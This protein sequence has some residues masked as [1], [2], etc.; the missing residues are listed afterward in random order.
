MC[1]P[2]DSQVRTLIRRLL[3]DPRTDSGSFAREKLLMWTDAGRQR[4]RQ[5]LICEYAKYE[6]QRAKSG[7]RVLGEGKVNSVPPA[8]VSNL[9]HFGPFSEFKNRI[10]M[11]NRAKLQMWQLNFMEDLEVGYA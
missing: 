1:R 9:V 5:G 10:K 3:V 7:W 6:A 4:R 8:M 11:M 2:V